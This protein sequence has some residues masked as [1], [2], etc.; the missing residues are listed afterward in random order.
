MVKLLNQTET[1]DPSLEDRGFWCVHLNRLGDFTQKLL[2][3]VS[4]VL[5]VKAPR[6]RLGR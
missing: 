1:P 6:E 5:P 3:G 4:Q 2:F